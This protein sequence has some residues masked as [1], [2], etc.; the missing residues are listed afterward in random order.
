MQI[1]AGLSRKLALAIISP[2]PTRLRRLAG[3]VLD[4]VSGSWRK[5]ASESAPCRFPHSEVRR[6]GGR[7]GE[8]RMQVSALVGCEATVFVGCCSE[9]AGVC[10][11]VHGLEVFF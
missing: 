4:C 1:L 10:L 5:R 3:F 8:V 11:G 6:V 2:I 9:P 7:D